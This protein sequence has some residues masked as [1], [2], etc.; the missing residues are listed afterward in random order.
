MLRGAAAGVVRCALQ[1]GSLRTSEAVLQHPV[2][3]ALRAFW[4]QCAG[5]VAEPSS[6]PITFGPGCR[7]FGTVRLLTRV[8]AALDDLIPRVSHTV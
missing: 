2:G 4:P 1:A 6:K 8:R 3:T 7:C 5:C